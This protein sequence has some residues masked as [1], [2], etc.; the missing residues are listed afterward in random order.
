[1]NNKP[2][3]CLL[4]VWVAALSL[5][6]T[7]VTGVAQ[8]SGEEKAAIES[9]EILEEIE[10]TGIRGS[11]KKSVDVKRNAEVIVDSIVAE[12]IGKLPDVTIADSLQRVTGVQIERTAGEGTSLNVRGMPQ[13]LT[14]LNGEQFLSPWTIT[15]VGANY[16]D[17]PASMIA[18]VDVYKS[19][20]AALPA[21]GISGVVDLKTRN[22]RG[23]EEG[24]TAA[25]NA[26]G[27]RGSITED[28]NYN[29]NTFVGYNGDRFGFTLGG[30]KSNSNSA[31]YQIQ[32]DMRLGFVNQ[33]GDPLDLNGN[34]DLNDR[35][36][37]PG[38]YGVKA[39]VMER[40]REGF[41]GSFQFDVSQS[42]S[43]SAD[44]FYT[45]MNQ[46]DRGVESQFNGM[47]NDNYDVLRPGTITRRE[48]VVPARG[49]TP[50]RVINS[51]QVAVVEAPDF[52]ATTRSQQNHTDALNTNIEL[53]FDNGGPFT[54]SVRYVRG[55]A[56]KTYENA[57]FQQGTPEWYWVDEDG[58]GMDDPVEPFWVTV[59][60]REDYPTFQFDDDLSSIDRLNLF[61]GFGDGTEQEASLDVFRA[62]GNY[63]FDIA[64]FTSVDFGVRHGR[65]DVESER[66]IYM[67]PTGYYSTWNDPSVPEELWYQPLPGD[68]AWQQYPDW[69]DFAGN[70]QLGIAPFDELRDMLISYNDF[71]PFKG[72][73]DGVAALDPRRLDDVN[74]FMNF[75]YPGA[76][77]FVD[78]SQ[79]YSV[80]EDETSGYFQLNFANDRGLFG[81]PFEGNFGVR[82]AETRREVVN[83][84]YDQQAVPEQG[85]Y[86]GGG[87][88]ATYGEPQGW[89]I[90]YKTLGT[91]TTK[92]SFTDVL[93]SGN[94]NFFP[95]EDVIVRLGYAETMSRNDLVNVGEG[96]SLWYQEYRVYT[97]DGDQEDENGEKY[98]MV[99]S[100]GGGN[101]QGNPHVDPWRANN[102][103]LSTEWYFGEGGILGAGLFLIEVESAT[104][105]LQEARAYP[106]SDGVVRRT[107]NIWTTKNVPASNL[108]GFELGYKQALTFLPGFLS[109]TG[110]EANYTFSDNDSGAVDLEGK[111]FPLN[112]NSRHQANL[113]LWYQGE[114]LSTRV[115]YN[116]RSDIFQGRAGLNTNEAPISLGNWVEPAG[117]LD[118]SINYDLLDNLTVYLQGTNLTETNYR[119]YA[120]F[121]SQLRS[122]NV[123]E[124]RLALGVRMR[125]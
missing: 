2:Q 97:P 11:Q 27:S 5:G 89:Q 122:I 22:P 61:Q 71:G 99:T 67:T 96:E 45:K 56:D 47:N 12:D 82:V 52:Q 36:L 115:A 104:Q 29:F 69:N 26:E 4:P 98:K 15:D 79:A 95:R 116:W 77:R 125:L 48:A 66:F 81:V 23:L 58:D 123:Q 109:D 100:P 105:T 83:A 108:K 121:E 120:Q 43:L 50:E 84:L 17:I 55:K 59:D 33:G 7:A 114:R 76:K 37:V 117:Y 35:Y 8:D 18:G 78:P 106:D 54:G 9:G 10:V 34:G 85:N 87:Y 25:A 14:T 91:E 51:L 111:S 16:S 31:N 24:W 21:G 113:I 1:M 40:E 32:E 42:L 20:G 3:K 60:Y 64:S 90:M 68:Y 112:S 49:D 6:A 103:N 65:R 101:D 28:D 118:A 110:I 46:F 73:G 92:A 62:D 93:P 19:Q 124:R 13:V 88:P 44:V 41:A 72:W 86:Y 75:L 70:E 107:A 30:F 119:N 38:G 57:I 80:V 39:Y 63:E 94:I 102:Y 53:K 74:G